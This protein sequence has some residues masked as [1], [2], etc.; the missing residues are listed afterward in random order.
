MRRAIR[1]G[2]RDDGADRVLGPVEALRGVRRAVGDG[3]PG[4]PV[5]ALERELGAVAEAARPRQA[6]RDTVMPRDRRRRLCLRGSLPPSGCSRLVPGR[7][8]DRRALG[9][10]NARADAK[11]ER[12][13]VVE[14]ARRLRPGAAPERGEREHDRRGQ[15]NC[16]RPCPAEV[17]APLPGGAAH[18]RGDEP[19]WRREA[20]DRRRPDP[21]KRRSRYRLA[22]PDD[23]GVQP[24][25]TGAPA[26]GPSPF[27]RKPS[28]PP[29]RARTTRRGPSALSCVGRLPASPSVE[30]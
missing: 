5:R 18:A 21:G 20:G 22:K 16:R 13:W 23:V 12:R 29:P 17:A 14:H 6:A 24:Q 9:H 8:P 4:D 30:T 1:G 26:H 11:R 2:H 7:R 25:L 15:C 10:R 28:S 27:G 3:V 19:G